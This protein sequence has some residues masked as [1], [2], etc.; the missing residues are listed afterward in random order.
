MRIIN[1]SQITYLLLH[2]V[3]LSDANVPCE[4]E[5]K[6]MLY[7]R[8]QRNLPGFNPN[9][10]HCLYGLTGVFHGIKKDGEGD[11]VDCK[12]RLE[13]LMVSSPDREEYG[14][15]EDDDTIGE[16]ACHEALEEARVKGILNESSLGMWEFK[17]LDT[18]TKEDNHGRRW[19][20]LV[21]R[22]YNITLQHVR[23]LYLELRKKYRVAT[24]STLRIF[25]ADQESQQSLRRCE[26]MQ[27]RLLR[28]QSAVATPVSNGHTL[29]LIPK[30]GEVFRFVFDTKNKEHKFDCRLDDVV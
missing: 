28:R 30:N 9:T 12:S 7:V 27:H 6:I 21:I 19:V 13:L 24:A 25:V 1:N 23:D 11:T 22:F 29:L 5:H 10:R 18:W 8:L 14:G 26:K 15:W 20:I 2:D 17:K 4:G 16:A 3:I